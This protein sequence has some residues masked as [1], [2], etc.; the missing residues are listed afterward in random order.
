MS[1]SPRL[2][3]NDNNTLAEDYV[4]IEFDATLDEVA[5]VGIRMV[6]R[7]RAYQSA[8]R[9]SQWG[10][11]VM[12]PLVFLAGSGA[13][14]KAVSAG[15]W[16][17]VLGVGVGLGVGSGLLYGSFHDWWVRSHHGKVVADMHAGASSVHCEVELRPESLWIRQNGLEQLYPWCGAT[18]VNDSGDAI[19]LWFDQGLV[20]LRNRV[21]ASPTSRRKAMESA[22]ALADKAVQHPL[23]ADGGA[24]GTRQ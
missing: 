19:E 21:F 16:G 1:I 9:R 5:D 2:E 14:S 18:M 13:L 10:F 6:R 24:G 8:R 12:L 17:I 22:T 11:G 20:V 15:D 4:R 3:S 23:A 7:T